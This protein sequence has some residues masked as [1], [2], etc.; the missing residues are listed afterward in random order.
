MNGNNVK[1]IFQK[2]N[3]NVKFLSI[4]GCSA[5]SILEDF[6]HRGYFYESLTIHSFDKK[7][8]LNA[9]IDQ[10]L[11][12]AAK[13][14]D[15][16]PRSFR[17]ASDSL[18]DINSF[19]NT[20]IAKEESDDQIINEVEDEGAR[21]SIINTNPDFSAE[22]TVDDQFIGLLKKGHDPQEFIIPKNLI[23][24]KTKLKVNFDISYLKKL[25]SLATLEVESSEQFARIDYLKDKHG[26]PY[27][28][29]TNFYYFYIFP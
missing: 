6:K 2:I 4:V 5:K 17:D 1:N 3:P 27:G 26:L 22:L 12:A 13:V 29:G 10:S 23:T 24:K 16:D 9:G 19:R 18:T 20:I 25:N 7:I 21:I 11:K 15:A 8:S 14:I 28:L